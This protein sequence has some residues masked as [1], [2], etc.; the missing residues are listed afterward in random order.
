LVDQLAL[1][2]ERDFG[3]NDDADFSVRSPI[4]LHSR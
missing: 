3:R 4:I 1:Q 2:I